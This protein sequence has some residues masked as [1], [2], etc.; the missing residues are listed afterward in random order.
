MTRALFFSVSF[1][2]LF[3]IALSTAVTASAQY[4]YSDVGWIVNQ[5]QIDDPDYYL[6][7]TV[8]GKKIKK[9]YTNFAD[10]I[11][12]PQPELPK[13]FDSVIDVIHNFILT[14]EAQKGP[15]SKYHVGPNGELNG[16]AFNFNRE[17]LPT[18][19]ARLS[20]CFGFDPF[21][22]TGL[23]NQES[24]FLHNAQSDT[25]SSGFTQFT[26]VAIAEVSEQLGILG[27]GFHGENAPKIFN[28][29]INCYLAG[30]GKKWINIWEAGIVS[31]GKEA[32]VNGYIGKKRFWRE[33][34]KSKNWLNEDPDRNLIY[35]AVL[36]KLYLGKFGNYAKALTEYNVSHKH[37]YAGKVNGFYN[38]I[39]PHFKKTPTSASA[40]N[41]SNTQLKN[42]Y[43][44]IKFSIGNS[45][46]AIGP[47][48]TLPSEDL[49]FANVIHGL[50]TE[51]EIEMT[52]ERAWIQKG[53]C[54]PKNYDI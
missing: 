53:I 26:G 4:R 41:I 51:S 33:V 30:S 24:R 3:L 46:C 23:I 40:D 42:T 34:S 38:E 22:F 13:E 39:I 15:G 50:Y 28:E 37:I 17:N 44:Q 25:G 18:K 49:N 16:P 35:G 20:F 6:P 52:L 19:I 43:T 2:I 5:T 8:T 14:E 48:E 36:L 10:F 27:N 29:Y 54:R 45:D 12:N 21:V 31:H 9:L 7:A 1:F 32:Y 47:D 11:D